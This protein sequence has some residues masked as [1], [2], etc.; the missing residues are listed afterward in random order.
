MTQPTRD[1]PDVVSGRKGVHR[2]G[3]AQHVRRDG[4]VAQRGLRRSSALYVLAENIREARPGHRGTNTIEK[5]FRRRGFGANVDPGPDRCRRLFPK[6]QDAFAPSLAHY[7]DT[8]PSSVG[9]PDRTSARSAPIRAVR[10]RRRGVTAR[11][12]GMRCGADGSY[13]IRIEPLPTMIPYV[14]NHLR[15]R[16]ADYAARAAPIWL[17]NYCD[18]RE[19]DRSSAINCDPLGSWSRTRWRSRCAEISLVSLGF[20]FKRKTR[21]V[22]RASSQIGMPAGERCEPSIFCL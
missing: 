18:V 4:P 10:P 13:T 16:P 3:V 8:P 19:F 1:L 5:E 17:R 6:G 21:P 2:A 20:P 14:L 9:R 7:A 15:L 12:F 22:W 11:E